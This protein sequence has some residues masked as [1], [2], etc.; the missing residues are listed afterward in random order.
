MSPQ[1][2][3]PELRPA[4]G[5]SVEPERKARPQQGVGR[6]MLGLASSAAVIALLAG[7][8]Y[9]GHHT[10]WTFTAP[11][12][13][14][15]KNDDPS[16]TNRI[17][18]VRFGQAVPTAARLPSSL[19]RSA[20]IE[21][22][23]S[24]AVSA[25]GID[26]TPAWREPMTEA[27]TANGELG[28]DPARV[29]RLS[30]RSPGPAWRV[31]KAMGDKVRAGEVMA[32]ID[33]GEVGKAKAEY[34]QALV[35]VRLKRQ[36]FENLKGV[37]QAASAQRVREAEAAFKDAEVKLLGA[38]QALANLGLPVRA[39]EVASLSPDEVARRIRLL[40]V[41]EVVEEGTSVTANLLPVRAPF[42]GVVLNAD[43][44]AGEVVNVTTVLFLVVD[45]SQLWLTLHVSPG[46]A[47][48]VTVGREVRFRPDGLNEDAVGKVT[49]IG[50]AADEATRTVPVR[51]EL[52]NKTG[53][54]RAS[55]F[56]K[57]RVILREER[58]A[59][60]VP[61]DAVQTIDGTP[62]VFVRDP[63]FLKAG[64]KKAFSVRPVRVGAN[65]SQNREIISGLESGEVVA[66]KGSG[67]LLDEFKRSLPARQA[68]E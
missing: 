53:Q 8:A 30:P 66:T 3:T 21:F 28:F 36:V 63:E 4:A 29:A 62:I 12:H 27:V 46:N 57:G 9:W 1:T 32:L 67:L 10:G 48:R 37:G 34:Q 19:Q 60:L 50:T 54:L 22:E 68:G 13:G 47:R 16:S 18:S 33:A 14:A 17:A 5:E 65:D 44:V 23:S 55:T 49:W 26:I 24:E 56:G 11:G 6:R 52:A 41:S 25:A 58:D 39:S 61:Q 51:V 42:D 35:Q 15:G 43:V 20:A 59:L 31:L 64:G 45:P 2:E 38:E 40:G 7:A